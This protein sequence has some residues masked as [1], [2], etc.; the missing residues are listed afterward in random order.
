LINYAR[1]VL[2]KRAASVI[3]QGGIVAYPTEAVWGLGCDPE[4]AIAAS[5]ILL[6]KSRKPNKG[7]ILIAENIAMFEQY[8]TATTGEQRDVLTRSWP[9]PVTWLVPNNGAA[10]PWITGGQPTLALRVTAHPV[11]AGLS[12]AYGGPVVS[13]SANPQGMLEAKNLTKVKTYFG[14]SIDGWA[15]GKIGGAKRSSEIR[16]LHSGRIIRSGG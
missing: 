14:D 6:L 2:V 8:L 4:N 10:P 7:L 3:A 9:G 15:P 13:T 12:K 1:H 16:D 5:R 11:A